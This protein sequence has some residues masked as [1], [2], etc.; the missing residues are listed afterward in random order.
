MLNV[1]N[2]QIFFWNL[3]LL[4]F[5]EHVFESILI[6]F[7]AF[8]RFCL[9]FFCKGTGWA[10]NCLKKKVMITFYIDKCYSLILVL[11]VDKIIKRHFTCRIHRFKNNFSIVHRSIQICRSNIDK[12]WIKVAWK[13]SCLNKLLSKLI[14]SLLSLFNSF[15]SQ[16][17]SRRLKI[18]ME[19]F[20][21]INGSSIS[22]SQQL[23]KHFGF[24]REH[25][26]DQQTQVYQ[27][28]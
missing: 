24:S 9:E 21:E 4:K 20:I 25:S 27:H 18:Q 2:V 12:F 19:V 3:M 11:W 17:A 8:K 7:K 13:K 1:H 22:M 14:S 16:L 10:P 23:Y 15:K 26:C 28:L 6:S 5:F